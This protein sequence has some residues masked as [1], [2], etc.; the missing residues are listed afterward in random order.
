MSNE[1]PQPQPAPVPL[2]LPAL[3]KQLDA[4][5]AM[6]AAAIDDTPSIYDGPE[7]EGF[8]TL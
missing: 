6:I 8:L 7:R 3:L 2:D 4:M 1:A 5:R